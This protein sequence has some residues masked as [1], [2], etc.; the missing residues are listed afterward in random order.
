MFGRRR[1]P[2]LGAAVVIGASRSAA[3]REVASQTQAQQNAQLQAN[4][5]AQNATSQ[6]QQAQQQAQYE[7]EQRKKDEDEAA[8]RTQLAID[9]A[10]AKERVR[11]EAEREK[12]R[13]GGQEFVGQPQQAYVGGQQQRNGGG[14]QQEYAPPYSQFGDGGGSLG[15]IKGGA[16][17]GGVNVGSRFC[18]NC[19]NQCRSLDKFCNA[20]GTRQAVER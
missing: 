11:G 7:I 1:A 15:D 10:I 20:C 19:G 13:G 12:G 5:A 4:Q 6:Q 2:V 8:R 18:G 16:G 9:E 3:R 14:Q 17:V